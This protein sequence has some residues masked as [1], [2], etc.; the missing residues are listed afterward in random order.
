MNADCARKWLKDRNH[1]NNCQCLEVEAQETYELF[2]SSLREMGEK[3]SDCACVKSEKTRTPYYDIE[4][5]GYT[6]CEKCEARIA[7]AGKHGVIKNRN[8]PT[9]WG[10][11]VKEEVLCSKCLESE[12]G[13]MPPLRRAEFNRY[14]KT[15]RL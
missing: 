6:Y 4:N 3:L 7:G 1:L 2:A 11:E 9:F 12:R 10:L 8:N 15:G 14:R 13:K 5:Y